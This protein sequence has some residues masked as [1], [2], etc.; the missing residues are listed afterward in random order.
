MTHWSFICTCRSSNHLLRDSEREQ[1]V[2]S[3]ITTISMCFHVDLEFTLTNQDAAC[4]QDTQPP[5]PKNSLCLLPDLLLGLCPAVT[6]HQLAVFSPSP[7]SPSIA[8]R[9]EQ[10]DELL[11]ERRPQ[12]K[13]REG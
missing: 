6:W 9:R 8:L 3:L 1:S 7:T 2:C 13:R 10:T 5:R 4:L 12:N 11:H